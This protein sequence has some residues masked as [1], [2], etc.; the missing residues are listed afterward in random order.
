MG[1][2]AEVRRGPVPWSQCVCNHRPRRASA[3]GDPGNPGPKEISSID[4]DPTDA[5]YLAPL[6]RDSR[7]LSELSGAAAQIVLLGS[8]ATSK[9]V[10]PLLGLFGERLFF[11][12]EFAGRGDMSRGGLMLRCVQSGVQLTYLPLAN[13]VRH[14]PKP[15]KLPPLTRRPPQPSGRKSEEEYGGLDSRGAT[16]DGH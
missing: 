15:P 11:P 12:A 1:L 13:A 4:I 6:Q 3:P 7:I 2:R 5:S 9:Y 8:I 14:G 16:A 10:E